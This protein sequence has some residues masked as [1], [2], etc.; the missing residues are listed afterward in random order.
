M[1]T[2]VDGVKRDRRHILIIDDT[3]MDRM[4]LARMLAQQGH[5][6]AM[7]GDGAEAL[8]MMR[9]VA[10]DLVLL[11]IM[12]PE[13]EDYQVLAHMTSDPVLRDIP[14]IVIAAI[15]NIESAGRS[16]EMGAVD[17]LPKPFNPTVLQTR[18]QTSLQRKKLHD[19]E[20]SYLEQGIRLQQ[21]EKLAMLGN[22]SAGIAHEL[23]NPV[24]AVLR[25]VK[26][27]EGAID[28]QLKAHFKLDHNGL[29]VPQ[30]V[31]LEAIARQAQEQATQTGELDALIRHD[32]EAE[33]EDW[34][35]RSG[36]AEGWDLAPTLVNMAI[37]PD[38]LEVL[39]AEFAPHQLE[40][41]LTWAVTRFTIVSV[42]REIGEG[43]GR[44]AEIVKALKTFTY[45]DQAP[46]QDVNVHD[47]LDNTLIIMRSKLQR[48]VSVHREYAADLPLIEARGS[49]LNQVWTNIIDNAIGAMDGQGEIAI[50]TSHDDNWVIVEIA[51]TGPGIP[52][53]IQGRIFDPFFTTKPPGV[54]TGL[55][56]NISYDIIVQKHKGK[57]NVFSQPGE[58]RFEVKLP[59][60]QDKA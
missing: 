10:F 39:A 22:L 3:P 28:Q 2:K 48:G 18:L 52:P 40:T 20:Q 11:D 7:A 27:L 15:D 45:V 29:T 37:D 8:V 38:R 53:D 13:M 58:T 57:M 51:D 5:T 4:T 1:Q 56:L 54:G 14:V 47:G 59:I 35:A 16:I 6:T 60:N 49:E 19:L 25:G 12:I 34:L 26:H 23:N 33:M 30:I 32:K 41:V 46:V 42:L 17:Y 24:A 43:S 36:V 44:V 50:K 9:E 31:V 21:S 55:G